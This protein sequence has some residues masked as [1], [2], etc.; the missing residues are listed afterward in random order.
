MAPYQDPVDWYSA[1]VHC[2]QCAVHIPDPY[3]DK[4]NKK[5]IIEG[6]RIEKRELANSA[7]TRLACCVQIKPD[8]NEMIVVVANNQSVNGDWFGTSDSPDDL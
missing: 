2:A 6:H 4:L 5:P 7:V 1:G 8:L 3:F